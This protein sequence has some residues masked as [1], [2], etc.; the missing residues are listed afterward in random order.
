MQNLKS[1]SD[2]QYVQEH[3]FFGKRKNR[4]KTGRRNF[5]KHHDSYQRKTSDYS[6]YSIGKGIA[7]YYVGFTNEQLDAVFNPNTNKM[8]LTQIQG[9]FISYTY[10]YN[11]EFLFSAT[12]GVSG[13]KNKEFEPADTFKSSR[14][15]AVN[16]FYQP[17]ET[18]RLGL[19]LTNGTRKNIDNQKGNAKRISMNAKFDF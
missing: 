7:Y 8:E 17:I 12:A 10:Q 9:G 2:S 3:R 14:Y 1:T 4:N 18:I 15:V 19:E 5:V 13:I 11:K 6:Q 16:G